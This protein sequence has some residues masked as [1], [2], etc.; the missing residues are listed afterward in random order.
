MK[1]LLRTNELVVLSWLQ[2]VLRGEGIEPVVLD[3]HS[4]VMQGSTYAIAR[5][6]MVADAVYARARGIVANAGEGDRLI[7]APGT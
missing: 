1:E 2:A 5:R 3:T 6:L 4:S 7:P